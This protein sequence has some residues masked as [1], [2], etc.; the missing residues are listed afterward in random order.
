MKPYCLSLKLERNNNNSYLRYKSSPSDCSPI[1]QVLYLTAIKVAQNCYYY[2][3]Q[4]TTT[5]F[6]QIKKN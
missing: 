2:K 3:C 6:E 1:L 4:E 5:I